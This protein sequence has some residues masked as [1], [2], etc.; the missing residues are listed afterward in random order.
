MVDDEEEPE[1]HRIDG[2]WMCPICGKDARDHPQS[3][4]FPWPTFVKLC[5]GREGKV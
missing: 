4:T 3:E 2:R 1:I 5:D